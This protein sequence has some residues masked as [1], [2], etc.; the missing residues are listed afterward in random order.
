VVCWI[1]Y[2]TFT[3]LVYFIVTRQGVGC[4]TDPFFL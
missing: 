1:G 4:P 3:I 2:L